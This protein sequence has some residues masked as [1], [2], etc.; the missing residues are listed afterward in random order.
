MRA[1]L[2]ALLVSLSF[3]SSSASALPPFFVNDL[4]LPGIDQP[5][6]LQ[7]L[8]DGRLLAGQK[9][10]EITILD[11]QAAQP[12]PAPFLTITDI[13]SAGERGLLGRRAGSEL[14]IEF[15]LLRR[16]SQSVHATDDHCEI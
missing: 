3:L 11:P 2:A 8:P 4:V 10:G 1:F 12:S 5:I 9:G 16:L 7:F 15:A 13:D 6:T 14:W